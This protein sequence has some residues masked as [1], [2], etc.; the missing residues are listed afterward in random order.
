LSRAIGY[1]DAAQ[2]KEEGRRVVLS[3]HA[4]YPIAI[5]VFTRMLVVREV[6][7][8]GLAK[9]R[10]LDRVRE[11]LR[12]RHYSRRTEKAYVATACLRHEAPETPPRV[13]PRAR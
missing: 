12:T 8:A 1:R 7:S 3:A 10:L 11:A 13:Q 4:G 5:T 6:A 2:H 9:S